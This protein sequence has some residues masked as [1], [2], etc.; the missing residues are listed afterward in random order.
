MVNKPHVLVVDDSFSVRM[1]LRAALSTAGFMVTACGTKE[2]ALRALKVSPFNLAI[3]DVVLPDGSGIDILKEIKHTPELQ[4]IRVFMLSSETE[5]NARIHGLRLGADL[6]VG[7][8]YDR[9]YVAR[10]ARELFKMSDYSG[11]PTSRRS[12]SNKNILIVDDSPTFLAALAAALR[13]DGHQVVMADSGQD[14]LAL[15]EMERFDCVLVDL[16]MPGLD[17]LQT[18]ARL[19]TL[20]RLAEV[21]IALMTSRPQHGL[22]E[23]AAAAGIDGV[24]T[25]GSDLS[26]MVKALR[27]L[28]LK[29]HPTSTTGE[30]NI[31]VTTPAE[32]ISKAYA[33]TLYNQVLALTGLSPLVSKSVIDRALHRVGAMPA[34]LTILELRQAI[35]HIAEALRTFLPPT[36]LDMRLT[37]IGRLCESPALPSLSTPRTTRLPSHLP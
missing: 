7:K 29:K 16:V 21:P 1:D 5:V 24:L 22:A 20:P 33:G 35:P 31:S 25:K 4:S 17:G 14:A 32:G 9:G 19:R 30:Q 27:E 6:Y 34:G 12:L 3:L 37:D 10:S 18:A 26:L 13:T 23:Q 36:E 2:A 15:A 28:L 8:P 11:A